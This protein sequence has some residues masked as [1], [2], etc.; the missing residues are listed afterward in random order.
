M[1][2]FSRQK[3]FA[4]ETYTKRK[5][6]VREAINFITSQGVCLDHVS[7]HKI[8]SQDNVNETMFASIPFDQRLSVVQEWVDNNTQHQSAKLQA[9]QLGNFGTFLSAQSEPSVKVFASNLQDMIRQR[10]NQSHQQI[11]INEFNL[12][13]RE[14]AF[15]LSGFCQELSMS[16]MDV[17]KQILDHEDP[18][19]YYSYLVPF[20]HLL[21]CPQTLEAEFQKAEKSRA[22]KRTEW[23]YQHNVT[24]KQTAHFVDHMEETCLQ[25]NQ[26][27]G[28]C[29]SQQQ[30]SEFQYWML[31][32]YPLLSVQF[33]KERQSRAIT[34]LGLQQVRDL[35][36]FN[37]QNSMFQLERQKAWRNYWTNLVRVPSCNLAFALKVKGDMAVDI[38][39]LHASHALELMTCIGLNTFALNKLRTKHDMLIFERLSFQEPTL[40]TF[41]DMLPADLLQLKQDLESITDDLELPEMSAHQESESA[42]VQQEPDVVCSSKPECV[43]KLTLQQLREQFPDHKFFVRN[44]S[45]LPSVRCLTTC[46]MADEILSDEDLVDYRDD[47]E[48]TE[49]L[50]QERRVILNAARM[51][52]W[53]F[54]K[55]VSFQIQL[56]RMRSNKAV[57][58]AHARLKKNNVY[59]RA[60]ACYGHKKQKFE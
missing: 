5:I 50:E 8:L 4:F 15:R 55:V 13:A 39:S 7:V 51:K 30:E 36:I 45:T 20:F 35:V 32:A 38:N 56:M 22:E 6:V 57:K 26:E 33:L 48:V 34:E 52:I 25:H 41:E 54:L 27:V 9:V 31:D 43:P 24:A 2:L 21:D 10:F 23:E 44:I 1:F 14:V 11:S 40:L 49:R 53:R 37:E 16:M 19:E 28:M 17:W 3:R 47:D 60:D 29:V 46:F 18:R 58:E 59:K 42:V 12:I